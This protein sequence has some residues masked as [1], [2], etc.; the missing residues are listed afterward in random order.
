MK[1][2]EVLS[3]FGMVI[4][5]QSMPKLCFEVFENPEQLEQGMEVK[6]SFLEFVIL[7]QFY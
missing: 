4:S 1:A 3:C 6:I 7:L 5:A 2:D